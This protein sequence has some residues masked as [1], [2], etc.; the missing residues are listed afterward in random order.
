MTCLD[1]SEC[2]SGSRFALEERILTTISDWT[3]DD[4]RMSVTDLLRFVRR[5]MMPESKGDYITRQSILAR[6]GFSDPGALFPCPSEIKIVERL[7]S[8]EAIRIATEK[9]LVGNKRICLHGEGG[10]G[11]TTALQEIDT[12]LPPGS[13][14][15]VFDC[16]GGGRYLD[17]D[18]Y[19]H[20]PP[21]AF[22]QLSNDLARLLRTPLLVSRSSDLDYPRFFKKRLEKAAEVVASEAGDALLVVVVDAADNSVTAAKTRSPEEKSFVHDFVALGDLPDNVRLVV[23]GRT[24]RLST[25]ELPPDFNLIDVKGFELDETATHVRGV[26][27]DAPDEWITDF[28]HLSRGNPRVQSY[29]LDYAGEEP[30][31]AL[32][33][34]RPRGKNL[35][36]VFREQMDHARHKVGRPQDI[37]AF[38]AGLVALPRPIPVPDLSAVT[39]LSKSHIRDLCTDLAPGVRLDGKLIGFADEDFEL[40]IRTE[41]E[42]YLVSIRGRIADHFV[43]HHKSD[44]YAATHVAAALLDAGRGTKIIELINSEQEPAAIGDPVLRREAQLQRLRIAMKVC[45]ET[46]NDVDA[47]LTL[48]IGAE[49][50][51]TDAAIRSMLIENPDLA[52][53][54]ARDTSGR[55]VLRD[56][57]QIENHG[58][59]LFHL[60]AA[61]ARDG[62]GISVREGSRQVRAWMQRRS[63]N[64]KEQ[65]ERHPYSHPHGWDIHARDIAA[66]TEAVIRVAGPQAAMDRLLR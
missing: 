6:L 38:C 14:V 58:P 56:P 45:R 50:L 18:A 21:D 65:K 5:A 10:C 15:L 32:D 37:K 52:A 46:G 25:L 60:M 66:Q 39:D 57:K 17:S 33:Y 8:R 55:I 16:Y 43:S 7:I 28:H 47:M 23:T 61:D 9:M 1:L 53:D 41:A 22:L 49:A 31:R 51:K 44:A 24:G 34:L 62:D 29:A 54:F 26:W 27:S 2:G 64:F 35:D 30:V 40:F 42:P 19:R 36:N 48:L 12:L 11:K 63:E 4:A 13:A 3:D 59:L 20:R